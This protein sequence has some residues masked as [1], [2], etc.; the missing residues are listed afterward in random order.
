MIDLTLKFLSEEINAYLSLQPNL[1]VGDLSLV[2]GNASRIF[3]TDGTNIDVPMTNRGVLSLV[4][5]EEERMIRSQDNVKRNADG[6]VYAEPPLFLNLYVLFVMN[7]RN[8]D[9][10]LKW[11]SA[12]LRYFQH[13]PIFQPQSHPNLPTGIE[14]I[15]ATLHTLSFEQANQL[16]SMLGGKYLP[17][18]LYKLRMVP[19]DENAVTAGGG[20]IKN[21]I[22]KGQPQQPFS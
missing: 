15:T 11:L 17:S 20:F 5:I 8:Q 18:V 13:Q 12:V 21:I 3:D 7:L 14:K 6:I 19:I 1:V 9:M 16:W 22:T 2:L 4:N 10:A